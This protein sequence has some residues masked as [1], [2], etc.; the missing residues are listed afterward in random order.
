MPSSCST[1]F[2]AIHFSYSLKAV[3]LKSVEPSAA[4]Y[5]PTDE[6]RT[7][8]HVFPPERV[9]TKQTPVA[10]TRYGEGWLGYVGDVNTEEG[11][12][13]VILAMCGL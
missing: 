4:V 6:S 13:E 8:S 3:F 1:I 2:P 11:S 9:D 10:F 5:L 7:E 12:D